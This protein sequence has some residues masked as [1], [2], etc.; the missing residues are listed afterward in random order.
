MS[1]AASS[2]TAA[3]YTGPFSVRAGVLEVF[4][5]DCFRAVVMTPDNVAITV[6]RLGFID[7]PEMAQPGGPEARDFLASLILGK[8]VELAILTKSST[9]LC[10]D[11]YSRLLCVPY[12]AS[13]R[14]DCFR[15]IELEMVLNGWAWI[16]ERYE[17]EERYFAALREARSNRRGIWAWEK[18]VHPLMFKQNARR[19][20]QQPSLFRNVNGCPRTHCSGHLVERDGRYGRFLGCSAYPT[21]RY[22]C[23]A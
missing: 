20:P 16:M 18:N 19:P 6:A 9:G 1:S 15:N 3:E 23:S 8:T 10:V 7:A 2:L 12:L 21:C 13:D 11:G 17:P 5:G 4:D 22:S 14:A